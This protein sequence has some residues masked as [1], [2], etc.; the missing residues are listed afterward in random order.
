MWEMA[1]DDAIAERILT[2]DNPQTCADELVALA[3]RNGGADNVA[4]LVVQV[5]RN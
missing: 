5:E 1:R 4:V 3:C 2:L